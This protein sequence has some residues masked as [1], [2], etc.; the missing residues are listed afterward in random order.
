MSTSSKP[1][2]RAD[3][4][5]RVARRIEARLV[6]SRDAVSTTLAADWRYRQGLMD[7]ASIARTAPAR[8]GDSE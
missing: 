2:I 4:R 7:A 5:E 1:S 3:E 8:S 6:E